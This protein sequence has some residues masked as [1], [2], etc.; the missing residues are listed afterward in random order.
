MAID[1]QSTTPDLVLTD[2]NGSFRESY[3][4]SQDTL[5]L[6]RPDGY[7]ASIS[8]GDMVGKTEAALSLLTP[9]PRDRASGA[10][11]RRGSA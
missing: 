11:P 8:L 4:V 3:G 2:G 1:A 5:F 10:R 7:L 9:L 6:V